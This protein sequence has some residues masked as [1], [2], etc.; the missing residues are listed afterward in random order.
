M[1]TWALRPHGVRTRGKKR[2]IW[3][4]ASDCVAMRKPGSAPLAARWQCV[5]LLTLGA[6]TEEFP[7]RQ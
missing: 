7:V 1:M 5:A 2:E 3:L 4:V 6:R